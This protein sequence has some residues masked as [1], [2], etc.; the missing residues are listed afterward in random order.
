MALYLIIQIS[1]FLSRYIPRSWRYQIGTAVGEAVFLVWS[2]KRRIL[3]DNTRAVLGASASERDVRTIAR[4]SMR[5]Y[6]KYLVEFLDLPNITSRDEI[7]ASMKIHGVEHLRDAVA[8]GKGVIIASAHF[9][10]IEVGGLRLADF[11]DVHAVYDTFRPAYLDRLIQRKRL[12]K[13]IHLVGVNDVRAMLRALRSGGSLTLLFDRPL[14][15]DEGVRVRFFGRETAVPGGPAVLAMKTGATLLPVYMFR[16]PDRTF[17]CQLFPPITWSDA[18][19]RDATVAAIMQ[20]LMDTL[21]AVVQDRPDQWYMFRPMWPD[22]RETPRDVHRAL[23]GQN[24]RS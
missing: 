5:N 2:T 16:Q 14:P 22:A 9:G 20:R 17:E 4:K 12:E 11:V 23:A 15:P 18:G 1:A 24:L 7:V 3:L 6:C 21:Q 10:T 13:G 19:S 8:R